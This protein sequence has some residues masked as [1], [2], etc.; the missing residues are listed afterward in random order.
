MPVAVAAQIALDTIMT[1]VLL[2][3]YQEN[4]VAS[5]FS[6][7]RITLSQAKVHIIKKDLAVARRI[8][9]KH[10]VTAKL[11]GMKQEREVPL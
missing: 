7:Y 5:R 11:S 4:V 9:M 6:F 8:C 10:A 2:Q 3:P 1:A